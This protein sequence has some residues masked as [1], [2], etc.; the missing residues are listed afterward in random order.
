MVGV[1]RGGGRVWKSRIVNAWSTL[2]GEW[3]RVVVSKVLWEVVTFKA[4]KGGGA[5]DLRESVARALA[6]AARDYCTAA[7]SLFRPAALTVTNHLSGG[8]QA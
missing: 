1:D 3:T 5:Q 2:G 4:F 8:E 7:D 6:R